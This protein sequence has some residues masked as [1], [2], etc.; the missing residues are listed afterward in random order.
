MWVEEAKWN[1]EEK[2]TVKS[3]AFSMRCTQWSRTFQVGIELTMHIGTL[4]TVLHHNFQR[5]KQLLA[6]AR[7]MSFSF[8]AARNLFTFWTLK[9]TERKQTECL[10]FYSCTITKQSHMRNEDGNLHF[11][12]FCLFSFSHLV[13]ETCRRMI[14]NYNFELFSILICVLTEISHALQ[15]TVSRRSILMILRN[16]FLFCYQTTKRQGF[17]RRFAY[18][19][20]WFLFLATTRWVSNGFY[21]LFLLTKKFENSINSEKSNGISAGVK[22]YWMNLD[23][24][25]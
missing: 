13:A 15:S 11:S 19:L 6:F 14:Y 23:D 17:S 7:Q 24:F 2:N 4:L 10:L 22:R 8:A 12:F 18:F 25:V 1:T 16:F 9:R 3:G 5:N 21:W 20:V